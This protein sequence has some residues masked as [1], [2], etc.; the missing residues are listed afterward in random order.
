MEYHIQ[1]NLS[2]E[3]TPLASEKWP[4]KSGGLS[5]GVRINTIM[6]R[7]TLSSGVSTGG[8]L[9]SGWHLK[10]GFTVYITS[11]TLDEIGDRKNKITYVTIK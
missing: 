6:F 1:W 5:S 3:A 10:R 11:S 9:S 2:C 4:F 8:G 7:F